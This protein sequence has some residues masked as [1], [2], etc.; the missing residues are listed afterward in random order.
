MRFVQHGSI[1]I[2]SIEYLP[3]WIVDM[4]QWHPI[5]SPLITPDISTLSQHRLLWSLAVSYRTDALLATSLHQSPTFLHCIV[6]HFL[7]S[8]SLF[9]SAL[10]KTC[11][12]TQNS[13]PVW[14]LKM[15]NDVISLR[16][17][18]FQDSL[19]SAFN[20]V[21]R[22]FIQYFLLKTTLLVQTHFTCPQT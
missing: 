17:H 7:S 11:K 9:K 5:L 6:K 22:R 21:S 2:S 1:D 15:N 4:T 19:F 8:E 12:P 3:R 10:L 16:T 14:S 18:C 13:F 20:L